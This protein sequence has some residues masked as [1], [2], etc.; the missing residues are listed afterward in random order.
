L[1]S[2]LFVAELALTGVNQRQIAPTIEEPKQYT[3]A[4][5]RALGKFV[6]AE[7]APDFSDWQGQYMVNHFEVSLVVLSPQ[8]SPLRYQGLFCVI[9]HP[10]QSHRQNHQPSNQRPH[11]AHSPNPRKPSPQTPPISRSKT[12]SPSLS[13]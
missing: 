6:K 12:R 11:P 7:I 10:Q 4:T 8:K 2:Q 13:G 9:P 1:I 3:T 5:V